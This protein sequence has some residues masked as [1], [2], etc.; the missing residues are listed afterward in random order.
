[1]KKIIKQVNSVSKKINVNEIKSKYKHFPVGK[2]YTEFTGINANFFTNIFV[3][4]CKK[5]YRIDFVND[6]TKEFIC[7]L[8]VRNKYF[9]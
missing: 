1:M 8:K 7:I 3:V 4:Y 6:V 5:N 2:R 9:T